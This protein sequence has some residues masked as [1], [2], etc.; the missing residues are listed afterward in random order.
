MNAICRPS[1]LKV[2]ELLSLPPPNVRRWGGDP[3]S[4]SAVTITRSVPDSSH[5]VRAR[6]T[7]AAVADVGLNESHTTNLRGRVSFFIGGL[8]MIAARVRST[9]ETESLNAFSRSVVSVRIESRIATSR[10]GGTNNTGR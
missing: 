1:G 8:R 10:T 4:P 2:G 3:P 5:V 6:H 9:R 7:Y